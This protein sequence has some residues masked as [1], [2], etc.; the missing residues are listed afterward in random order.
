MNWKS[1]Q[2]ILQLLEFCFHLFQGEIRN[3]QYNYLF[4]P[5]SLICGKEDAANNYSRG[6]YTVGKEM[7]Y[8]IM[9]TIRRQVETCTN[10]AGFFI[11]HSMGGGTGSGLTSL[12][13]QKLAAEYVKKHKLEF[14]VYPCPRVR[15]STFTFLS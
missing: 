11:F 14:V 3:N 7:E 4:K 6:F 10:L 13:M 8:S 15:I 9:D 5:S 2:I 1:K 12:I